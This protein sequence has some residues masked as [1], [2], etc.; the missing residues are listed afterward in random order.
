[1]K[2]KDRL[3]GKRV[4]IVDDEP[5]V[6]DTLSEL[7]SMRPRNIWKPNILILQFWI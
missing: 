5:D 2:M 6:L 7:L 4:L 3:E 1:M